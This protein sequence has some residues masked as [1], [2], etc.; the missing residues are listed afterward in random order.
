M[1]LLASLLWDQNG[2]SLIL[3]LDNILV[4][5]RSLEEHRTNLRDLFAVFRKDILYV[6]AT[7]SRF[8]VKEVEFLGHKVSTD[9]LHIQT[10]LVNAITKWPIP[11]STKHIQEFVGLANY[12]RRFVKSCAE[13][14]RPT[15]YLLWAR[16]FRWDVAQAN[17]FQRIKKG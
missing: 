10:R 17:S 16:H 8:G 12:Y 5:N 2:R 1:R 9:G 13:I 3:Y 6:H 4:F 7:K 11:S 14:M 15:T